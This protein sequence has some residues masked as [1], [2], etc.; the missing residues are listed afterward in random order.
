MPKRHM[1]A[2]LSYSSPEG[3]REILRHL[4]STKGATLGELAKLRTIEDAYGLT[5]YPTETLL[6]GTLKVLVIW[7]LVEAWKNDELVPPERFALEDRWSYDESSEFRFFI[8]PF[9][10]DLEAA[11]GISFLR[12]SHPVLGTPRRLRRRLD[13]FV[14]MPFTDALNPVYED[15]I[16]SVVTRSSLAIARADDF[17]THGTILSDIWTAINHAKVIIADC[18]GRNPNVFYEIG[19]AHC[20][21]K[22]T[23]LVTQNLDDVPFDLRHLR[24]LQYAYNPRGMV[25]FEKALEQ[26][27]REIIEPAVSPD[28]EDT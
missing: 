1:G 10:I 20:L 4:R 13:V 22:P 3:M 26:T 11:F 25:D 19:L 15:H 9:C 17:F 27:I 2:T 14:L 6:L 21:G 7:R 28:P 16:K 23:V 12:G 24:V 18:T 5:D 8:S